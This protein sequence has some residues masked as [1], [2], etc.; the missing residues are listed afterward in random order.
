MAEP[1]IKPPLRFSFRYP[2]LEKSGAEALVRLLTAGSTNLILAVDDTLTKIL[3]HLSDIGPCVATGVHLTP[4]GGFVLV[5]E[6]YGKKIKTGR[7]QA[8]RFERRSMESR[9]FCPCIVK[10]YFLTLS[11]SGKAI[12]HSG[13]TYWFVNLGRPFGFEPVLRQ[14]PTVAPA[15]FFADR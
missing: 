2:Q 14:L 9:T 4:G 8:L 1:E 7:N 11:P 15:T 6:N 3:V 12:Y 5:E 10:A 13:E